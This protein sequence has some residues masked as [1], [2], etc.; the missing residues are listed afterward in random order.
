MSTNSYYLAG[1]EC[2]S[3]RDA[4]QYTYHQAVAVSDLSLTDRR[5]VQHGVDVGVRELQGAWLNRDPE[6]LIHIPILAQDGLWPLQM[7]N[8]DRYSVRTSQLAHG[9][10]RDRLIKATLTTDRYVRLTDHF[11]Y[12]ADLTANTVARSPITLGSAYTQVGAARHTLLAGS[13]LQLTGNNEWQTALTEASINRDETQCLDAWAVFSTSNT[14]Q[15]AFGLRTL[16]AFD[17]QP[18]GSSGVGIT[19]NAGTIRGLQA[20]DSLS[21]SASAMSGW[22]LAHVS[23]RRGLGRVRLWF[24]ASTKPRQTAIPLL[25]FDALRAPSEGTLGMALSIYSGSAILHRWWC[26]VYGV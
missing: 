6:S 7:P 1:V 2:L 11:Q 4:Q 3:E 9:D 16:G 5:F 20:D 23:V 13:G 10:E 26:S 21:G 24:S 19:W 17:E 15:G 8:G 18:L 25:R 14:A 22:Y 12:T